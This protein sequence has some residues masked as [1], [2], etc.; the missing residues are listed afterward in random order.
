MNNNLTLLIIIILFAIIISLIALLAYLL[1][2]I[3]RQQQETSLTHNEKKCDPI[4]QEKGPQPL[5]GR[6]INHHETQAAGLC[7]ICEK[8]FCENCL[9]THET[10]NFCS[11]HYPLFLNTQWQEIISVHTTPQMPEKGTFLYTFK[12]DIW[13]KENIPTY[14]LT[15]YKINPATD[16]IESIITLY[17]DKKII[18]DLKKR[19]TEK[20]RS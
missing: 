13:E 20:S 7:N 2:R 8:A 1:I 15:H 4:S 11:D 19:I 16:E 3:L 5:Y 9:H 17:G 12:K 6:C 10:L 18:S 14:L